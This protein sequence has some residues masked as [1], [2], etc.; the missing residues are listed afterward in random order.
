MA[1]RGSG[2]QTAQPSEVHQT[3]VAAAQRFN[4][5]SSE[6]NHRR[7]QPASTTENKWLR[8]RNSAMAHDAVE[9][10]VG[11]AEEVAMS[12][13]SPHGQTFFLLPPASATEAGYVIVK[14]NLAC[15]R[16]NISE[17][18]ENQTIEANQRR[19]CWHR[20]PVRY[21]GTSHPR[22]SRRPERWYPE[23][24]FVRPAPRG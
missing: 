10:A 1:A 6:P 15:S 23:W 16:M 3:G 9:N 17:A 18:L 11:N 2:E 13:F 21:A 12:R 14:S 7:Q 22:H 20:R 24:K 4:A 5:P 8:H 19:P